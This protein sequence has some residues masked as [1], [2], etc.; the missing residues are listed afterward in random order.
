MFNLRLAFRSLLRSPL[1]TLVAALSLA[2]GIGANA[3]IF[4]IF[5]TVVLRPLPVQTPGELVNLSPQGPMSGSVSM[6]NAGR[7]VFSYAMVR[8]LQQEQDAFTG[9]AAHNPFGANLAYEGNTLSG[10]GALVTGNYFQVLGLNPAAGR[11]FEPSDDVSPNGHPIVVLSYAYWRTRFDL[12]PSILNKA[13]QVNGQAMTVVGVAPRGFRGTTLGNDPQIF[14]PLSMRGSMIPGWDDYEERRSYWAYAFARLKPG[15]SLEEAQTAINVPYQNIIREIELPLQQ[16][17]SEDYL[18]R[19]AE[20]TLVL[21]AGQ[22][23]QSTMI[24]ETRAPMLLLLGVTG[25]V[26]LIA[27]A[28]I[29]NLLLTKATGRANEI[30]LRMSIGAHRYQVVGQL[31]AESLLLA[32]IGGLL[33]IATARATLR[34][35]LQFLPDDAG[36]MLQFQLGSATGLFLLILVLLTSL[37]GLFPALHATR[38]DLAG[39]LKGGGGRNS[40][41]RGA[42]R[43]RTGM[44]TVQIALSMALLASAGLFTKSLMNVSKVDLGLQT[45]RL[46]VFGLSPELNGYSPSDSQALFAR[47]EEEVA[48]LPGVD[49]VGASMVPLISG[50]NWGSNVSVEGYPNDPDTDTQANYTEIGPEFFSTL[51]IPLI[52]G[53]EFD[54]RD[55]AGAPGAVIVNEA[56]AKKFELGTS[57]VG[58]RMQIGR[59][60]EYDLEIVG[61]VQNAKYSEV[62]DEVPPLFY[63]P[64]KQNQELGFM[65]FY[66]RSSSEPEQLLST[67]RSK[68]GGLDPSLPIENLQTMEMQVT[69]SLFLDRMMTTLT[70]AFAVLATLLAAVGLYGVLAYAVAQRTREIGLRMALGAAPHEVR[71]MILRQVGLLTVPGA[72]I[73]LVGAL[74]LGRLG[75][76]L[77]FELDGHDPL[78]LMISLV[79]LC[80]VALLAGLVPAR[81]ASRVDP[82]VALREE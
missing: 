73:G 53:R 50:N 72:I 37:A 25:F 17:A 80:T 68:V 65:N 8:D 9:I 21:K 5:E 20:K 19:F 11:L 24:E 28:N 49:G 81:K 82:M 52:N 69:Q 42:S 39:S 22:K 58:R 3:A 32:S 16:G 61:L 36:L 41:S 57:A 78:V 63:L 45:D 51:G 46:A 30:A 27:C 59:G 48:A 75:A 77:L 60:E 35:M 33:G 10:E 12:D 47:I 15:V 70:T 76:S 54:E 6:G 29:A 13:L 67:L 64:Y 14:V 79:L 38:H 18:E 4:S 43:F 56:F 71:N 74:G 62:K 23:G 1:I 2:L 7:D 31:M 44:A 66:V 40:Q 34:L 26:L 55:V